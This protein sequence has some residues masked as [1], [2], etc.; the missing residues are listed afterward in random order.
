MQK[1]VLVCALA[2]ASAGCATFGKPKSDF[3]PLEPAA[4]YPL[5]VGNSWTYS[6]NVLGDHSDQTITII[7][8]DFDYFVDDHKGRFKVDAYGLRDD[9]RYLLRVPLELG[10]TWTSVISV[11]SVEH[12][13]VIETDGACTVLAGAFEHCLT[14]ES[15]NRQDESHTLVMRMTFAPYVGIVKVE[16]AM[17]ADGKVLP[18]SNVEL[19]GYKV[20]PPAS[21]AQ[22]G[23]GQ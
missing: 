6:A 15:T 17:E 3:K 9:K 13:R 23:S 4:Y 1:V 2:A 8:K 10:R 14:V 5:A 7:K 18:Q 20:Q 22:P 11:Q 16:T 21:T 19:T 12:A